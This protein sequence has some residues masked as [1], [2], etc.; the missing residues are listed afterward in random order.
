MYFTISSGLRRNLF[1]TSSIAITTFNSSARGIS[2]RI[3]FWE[4]VQ[5]SWY[6]VCGFTTAGT[7]STTS[8]PQS[9]ALC[10]DVRIPARLFSTT[11][12]SL[13]DSGYFQWSMF[14]TE[15][16]RMFAPSAAFLISSALCSSGVVGACITSKPTSRAIFMRSAILSLAGSISSSTPF[17]IGRVAGGA[18]VPRGA[19][20][21]ASKS[22]K[23][24]T[25]SPAEQAVVTV[26]FRNSRREGLHICTSKE[27]SKL[28]RSPRIFSRQGPPPESVQRQN[29]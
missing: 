16:I 18:S 28:R 4:R 21:A 5:A 25:L 29:E 11:A 19:G 22:A 9:L 8:E 10:S 13:D 24:Q 26:D 6:E 12:G 7:S 23:P 27:L 3:C 2:L 1:H 17:L 14:I 15:S 20:E